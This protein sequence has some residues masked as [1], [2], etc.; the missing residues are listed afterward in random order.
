MITPSNAHPLVGTWITEDED[1]DAAFVV[2]VTKGRFV[3][4]GF[5]RSDGERF[6]ITRTQWDGT[7][8]SFDAL[9]KSTAWKTR[10]VLRLRRDGKADLQVTLWEVWKKKDA[11]PGQL[12]EAWLK[13]P[14]RA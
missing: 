9:M 10:N 4:S 12:P 8:L 11:K 13:P 14:Q 6:R 1:S 5:C 3:V 2:K 7:N